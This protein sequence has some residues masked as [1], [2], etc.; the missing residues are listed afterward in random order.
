MPR[1]RGLLTLDALFASGIVAALLIIVLSASKLYYGAVKETQN[2][3]ES[4]IVI[5]NHL[6]ELERI[7]DWS[8]LGSGRQL[9]EQI[10]V[11]YALE[12]TAYH[13]QKLTCTFSAYGREYRMFLERRNPN[14]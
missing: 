9:T 4:L 8:T 3:Y 5:E 7:A 12:D 11:S 13:T 1:K 10:S 14:G 6:A 2:T